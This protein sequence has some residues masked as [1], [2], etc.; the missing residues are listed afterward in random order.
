MSVVRSRAKFCSR[1]LLLSLAIAF[2]GSVSVPIAAGTPTSADAPDAQAAPAYVDPT[3]A[4]RLNGG[5][6][7][8]MLVYLGRRADLAAAFGMNWK[9]RGHY[10]QQQLQAV[11]EESQRE[12]RA[13][14][15]Q[16]GV[17][18][19][20]FW[21]DNVVFVRDAD[22]PLL[23]TLASRSA[24]LTIDKIVGEP[25]VHLIE[26]ESTAQARLPALSTGTAISNID[27]VRA[28]AVWDLGFTGRG[29]TV[30]NIDTGVRHT[31]EAIVAG[32]RGTTGPGQYDHNYNWWSPYAA[33]TEPTDL[34]NHGSHTIGT[35]VGNGG[36]DR[37]IGMAP[38][39][40]WMACQGFTPSSTG[41]GLLECG[42]FML[43]PWNLNHQNPDPNRRPHVI[44]NSWSDCDRSVDTW[45]EGVIDAWIA[46]GIV[47]VFSN[48]NAS[49]CSYTRPPGLNTIGNPAR[50]GKSFSIGSTGN[51]N[52]LYAAHSNWGPTDYPTTGLPNYP[53]PRGYP[54]IKPN[55]V[56]PGVAV[57][58][59]GKDGN[60]HYY[61]STGTSMSAPHVAG[62]VA[63]MWE[64]A[65]CLVG[66]YARTGTIIMQTARPVPYATG[67]TPAP[68]P[69]NV[70][71][72]ATGWG[73][74]DALGAVEAA[75]Q[76]CGGF[77][78]ASEPQSLRVCA[79]A[80]ASYGLRLLRHGAFADA[81]TLSVESGLPAGVIATFS[82]NPV[83]PATP[84][85]A[86]TLTI[87]GTAGQPTASHRLTIKAQ[88]AALARRA[89]V[90]LHIDGAPLA[91]PG[92]GTP[93]AGETNVVGRPN[94]TW[95][96]AADE[97]YRIQI[98]A[99]AA[100]NAPVI[101]QSVIATSFRPSTLLATGTTYYWRVRGENT[102]GDGAWSAVGQ[103]TTRFDPRASIAPGS[104]AFTQTP[105][106]T[107]TRAL[108]V[109]NT[110][111]ANL[112][113]SA[114]EA[115]VDDAAPAADA[116]WQAIG[117]IGGD[118]GTIVVSPLDPEVVLAGTAPGVGEGNLY[119]SSDGGAT[120][121]IVD[122]NASVY[123]ITFAS[124]GT[125]YAATKT[126]VRKSTDNGLTWTTP[127]L[128]IGA[129]RQT[130]G[131]ATA[132]SNASIVWAGVAAANGQQT[133]NLLRSTNAGATW[134][135]VTPALGAA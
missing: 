70:P 128:N 9:E 106:T 112:V 105:G 90:D 118:L 65:P 82:S 27:H 49:N 77:T 109:A 54:N 107:G 80:P 72:Y 89:S 131:V 29:I 60:D 58:S 86:S 22:R 117:P 39:A 111:S 17:E 7:A 6:K 79:A 14:L 67:G 30:A 66:D 110:G 69:G 56:A 115:N 116:A 100:F 36:A 25:E 93:T 23:D 13:L 10:V 125:I 44:N 97:S 119:R 101:D 61:L 50:Y 108:D 94:F 51:D 20:A 104:L 92:L 43:A 129:N 124:D 127:N 64:A 8:N 18:Y 81:V 133:K 24:S 1:P 2:A 63:L 76:M 3:L 35:M 52:G 53:D 134:T 45:Y 85:A 122:T 121:T 95:S 99:D 73:E 126:G 37:R 19:Q 31:H 84:A 98:A 4:D 130:F 41:A 113:W 21:I 28:P 16:Q 83:T 71:N 15:E 88:F 120:W 74:I 42:Q 32:Y 103:F 47:P 132:P 75:M 34:H 38:G 59:A 102:C 11:A 40:Q 135:N 91:A 68:G 96:G 62:L 78:I 48:G 33:T 57:L 123:R 46:A 55:V 12:L 5:G 114:N 26:P 87:G